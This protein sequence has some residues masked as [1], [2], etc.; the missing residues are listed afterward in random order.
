MNHFINHTVTRAVITFGSRQLVFVT[1]DGHFCEDSEER[2]ESGLEKR[3]GLT[4]SRGP[5]VG[6]ATRRTV[7]VVDPA[8][9][10]ALCSLRR[11][12]LEV[13]R[14]RICHSD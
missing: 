5:Q 7:Y 13:V 10:P 1:Y 11:W 2:Q 4:C 6:I 9:R 8:S 14:D 12:V 3:D